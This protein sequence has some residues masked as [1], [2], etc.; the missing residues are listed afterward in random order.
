MIAIPLPQAYYIAFE[1]IEGDPNQELIVADLEGRIVGT[2]QLSYLASLSYQGGSA[3]K[4][5][6]SA[7][8]ISCAVRASERK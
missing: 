2:L 1:A 6:P 4:S 7:C 8:Y 5:N 3:R